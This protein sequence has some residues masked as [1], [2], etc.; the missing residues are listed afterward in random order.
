VHYHKRM[1]LVSVD[2]DGVGNRC[3]CQHPC[4]PDNLCILFTVTSCTLCVSGSNTPLSASTCWFWTIACANLSSGVAAAD[5]VGDQLLASALS[6]RSHSSWHVCWCWWALNWC[7]LCCACY[8]RIGVTS[9]G[10]NTTD[11]LSCP[12]F[13]IWFACAAELLA[14]KSS[15]QP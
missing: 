5:N 1:M 15:G 7:S 4:M 13:G 12:A 14:A 10:F 8:C 3:F 6:C 11:T 9:C 2:M